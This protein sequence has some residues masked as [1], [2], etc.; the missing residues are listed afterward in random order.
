M[1]E[2][3]SPTNWVNVFPL[4]DIPSFALTRFA[5]K[6]GPPIAEWC[7]ARIIS[8]ERNFEK[9]G[10]D[11]KT[12]RWA[13]S[14]EVLHYRYLS[15]LTLTI[16]GCGDIGMCIAKA[17]KAFGMRVVGYVRSDRELQNFDECSTCLEAMMQKADYLV[18]VLPSTSNTLFLVLRLFLKAFLRVPILF[19]RPFFKETRGK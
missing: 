1:G 5:G 11:Q 12:K 19:Q 4:A 8:H 2:H 10:K 6:F 15:D 17:A 3:R 16:L 9:S 18:S 14:T 13:G 7:L